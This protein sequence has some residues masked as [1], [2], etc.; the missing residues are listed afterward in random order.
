MW[1]IDYLV[2]VATQ[3]YWL[4]A[5]FWLALWNTDSWI[6]W[7]YR[8]RQLF[9]DWY[10]RAVEFFQEW[11]WNKVKEWWNWLYDATLNHLRTW[12]GQVKAESDRLAA[13]FQAKSDA[14]A[15]WIQGVSD[16][17]A[18]RLQ[19]V[20]NWLAIWIQSVSDS[21]AAKIQQASDWLAARI[22][23]TA[24]AI[25]AWI[26]TV[27]GRI[28]AWVISVQ[29][30]IYAWIQT[31]Y[32]SLAAWI[33]RL[34]DSY[35][36]L[37]LA[38]LWALYATLADMVNSLYAA[39]KLFVHQ[40]YPVVKSFLNNPALFVWDEIKRRLEDTSWAWVVRFSEY[41]FK[42]GPL[43]DPPPLDIM[44]A[45]KREIEVVMKGQEDWPMLEGKIK[46]ELKDIFASID[47][48]YQYS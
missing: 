38:A 21:I 10:W 16:Y 30:A 43:P 23:S 34:S 37:Q 20:S 25:Y 8:A 9:Y 46:A 19:A 18:A 6:S 22:Q 32:D 15:A 2:G 48:R 3:V 45:W 14:L 1:I 26:Q 44:A 29:A 13:W 40:D 35:N 12:W 4:V 31:V 27:Y 17:A 41:P 11:N 7:G 5:D 42:F 33:Q 36:P 24:D 39:L 47:A 28:E